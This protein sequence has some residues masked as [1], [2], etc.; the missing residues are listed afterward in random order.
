MARRM[1]TPEEVDTINTDITNLKTKT[2]NIVFENG[3]KAKITF[4]E[5]STFEIYVEDANEDG[6][7]YSFAEDGIYLD[8][9]KITN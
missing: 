9:V 4:K 2:A 7:T 6:Y 3:S 1:I 5:D 8:G